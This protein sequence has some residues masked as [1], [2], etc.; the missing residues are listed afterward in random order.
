MPDGHKRH[1]DYCPCL[2][3]PFF[4]VELCDVIKRAFYYEHRVPA[5]NLLHN[6][7]DLSKDVSISRV[8]IVAIKY[9]ISRF[10]S[11]ND[12]Q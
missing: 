7:F 1:A 10:V 12:G 6:N 4:F 3:L 5:R 9:K 11:N 2:L 8:S